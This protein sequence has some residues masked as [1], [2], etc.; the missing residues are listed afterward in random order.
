MRGKAKA[1]LA[2]GSPEAAKSAIAKAFGGRLVF[3]DDL[4][5]F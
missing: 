4:Q 1:G 2:A 3:A 5:G